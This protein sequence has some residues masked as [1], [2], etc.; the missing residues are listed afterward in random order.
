MGKIHPRDCG[1]QHLM[2][3]EDRRHCY[4]RIHEA[5][6]AARF[7]HYLHAVHAFDTA[8]DEMRHRSSDRLLLPQHLF[9]GGLCWMALSAWGRLDGHNAKA[10]DM[11]PAF[12]DSPQGQFLQV[13]KSIGRV[14]ELNPPM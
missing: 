5:E 12:A 8:L 7:G 2:I 11:L 4:T 9:S 6:T 3:L 14:I 10:V 13:S 1:I